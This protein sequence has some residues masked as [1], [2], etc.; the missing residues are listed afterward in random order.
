MCTEFS[1]VWLWNAHMSDTLGNWGVANGYSSTMKMYEWLNLLMQKSYTGT[2]VT[3]E[4][5]YSYFASTTWYPQNWFITF[6]NIFKKYNF[7]QATYGAQN[8]PINKALTTSSDLWTVNFICNGTYLGKDANGLGNKNPLVYPAYK[9]I[10]D[11]LYSIPSALKNKTKLSDVFRISP[12]PATSFVMIYAGAEI[13][14]G[15]LEIYDSQSKHIY[16]QMINKFPTSINVAK[17][18]MLKG[19]YFIGIRNN[20]NEFYKQ[21]IIIQ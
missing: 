1:L 20:M 2:P 7:S 21:K 5:F 3:P 13:N 9:I 11:S 16:S 10:T 14:N 17:C 4:H 15:Q 8:L 19:V 6:Y 12:N 18:G